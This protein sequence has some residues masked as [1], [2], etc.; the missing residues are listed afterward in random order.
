MEGETVA[1]IEGERVELKEKVELT[2]TEGER[3]TF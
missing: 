3:V 1:L 2:L